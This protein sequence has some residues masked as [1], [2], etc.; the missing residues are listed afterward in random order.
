[1]ITGLRDGAGRGSRTL[2]SVKTAD[3]ESAAY[4]ISPPRQYKIGAGEGNRTLVI[5]LEGWGSTIELHPQKILKYTI[6]VAEWSS[7]KRI[8]F[9]AVD[10]GR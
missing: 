3:F 5:S 9:D 4:A 8:F 10:R 6:N 1:M 2:T 7:G